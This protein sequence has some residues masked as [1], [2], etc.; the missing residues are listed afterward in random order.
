MAPS[1]WRP[2]D[3]PA[4]APPSSSWK[5]T[6]RPM[7]ARAADAA[8]GS[9]A[10]PVVVV[11]GANAGGSPPRSPAGGSSR[12]TMRTGGRASRPRYA[13]GSP[14]SSPRSPRLT[15]SS[16]PR[17]TS[18]RFPRRRSRCWPPCT[19]PRGGFSAA[20]YHGR[21]GAPAVFGRIHFGALMALEGDQGARGLLNGGP[22][23]VAAIDMPELGIDLD[24]PSD[25]A[26]WVGRR[27]APARPGSRGPARRPAGPRPGCDWPF[28]KKC[29]PFVTKSRNARL[30]GRCSSACMFQNAPAPA[31][32]TSCL[33]PS[34]GPRFGAATERS[35][36]REQ[37]R[38]RDR[39]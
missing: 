26:D 19:G 21:N 33:T 17:A 11:L 28:R 2:A 12:R 8:L 32:G 35:S 10:A 20:R 6:A 31:S 39:A 14:P 5:S 16:S 27:T 37:A 15:R 18:R 24:T 1:F 22:E 25:Y 4:W 9:G 3:H 38:A 29:H 7:V 36:R 30:P 34:L 13:R 23:R